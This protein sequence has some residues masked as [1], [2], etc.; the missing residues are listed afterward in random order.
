MQSHTYSTIP[1]LAVPLF[2]KRAAV[3]LSAFL[4]LFVASACEDTPPSAYVPV[5]YVEAYLFVD[6]PI[7]GVTVLM[8]QSLGAPYNHASAVVRDAQVTV[9]ADGIDYPLVFRETSDGGAYAF[10][11]T[12]VKVKPGT[13][14]TLTVRLKDGAVC[15]GETVTPQRIGWTRFPYSTLQ[16]PSDTTK[17]PSPDSLRIAWSAG[18]NAEFLI[19]VRCL[20]TLAY[21]ALLQP[22]TGEENSR[23]NNLDDFETPETPTFYGTARWGYLQATSAPTV[24]NVFK[25]HGRNEVAIIAPDKHFLNWFKLTRFSGAPQYNEEFSNIRGGTGVFGSAASATREVFLFK[26]QK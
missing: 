15:T 12:S 10:P 23:T 24:W 16:Y 20:D 11:D 9:A 8:S 26:R 18:S 13:T 17:L 14:Y 6:A 25:W 5:P 21:G 3:V 7:E 1:F 19:R 22:P 4:L 2:L